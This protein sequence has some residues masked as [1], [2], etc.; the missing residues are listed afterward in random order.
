M[1]DVACATEYCDP[2][3]SR[4]LPLYL[5]AWRGGHAEAG[6][7]AKRL[8]AELG[9]HMALGEIATTDGDW[10]AAGLAFF[11]AGFP[12]LAVEPLKKFVEM[13]PAGASPVTENVRVEGVTA[14][15]TIARGARFDADREI[16][17]SLTRARSATGASAAAAYL[18]A[19]RV[20]RAAHLE[21]RLATILPAA[22]RA[23]PD[24]DTIAA[25]VAAR[26]FETGKTDELLA[27][28]TARLERSRTRAEHAERARAAGVELIARNLQPG[29][30]LRLLRMSL[31]HAYTELLPGITSHVAVWELLWTHAQVQNAATELMPLIV[32][33]LAAPL[34]A[35]DALYLA[36]LALEIT[37]RH[38][39]DAVAARPYAAMVI[40]FVPDHSLAV[41]FAMEAAPDMVAQPMLEEEPPAEPA[42]TAARC[43]GTQ[44]KP[45]ERF[46]LNEGQV[47][48]S[49]GAPSMTAQAH[50]I[51]SRIA[52][53]TSPASAPAPRPSPPPIEPAKAEV[54]THAHVAVA[55]HA[56][57]AVARHAQVAVTTHGPSKPPVATSSLAPNRPPVSSK[58]PPIA[59][60]PPTEGRPI[61]GRPPVA[62]KPNGPPAAA[63][64]A[65]P[66]FAARALRKVGPI[67]VV[68]ELPT[69]GF[70]STLLRDLSTS[71]AFILTKRQLDVGMVVSLEMQIPMPG[72]ATASSHRIS[73]RIVR[74]AEIGCG[75]AFID[76]TPE[77]VAAIRAF[78]A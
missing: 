6:V 72:K 68:V 60:K 69:G 3:R 61:K 32:Q 50:R 42:P 4:G 63:L 33:A 43:S 40:D 78:I 52:L 48:R 21:D 11:D 16:T 55:T 46:S 28:Y 45:T 73:A 67:D 62:G 15:F 2:D 44:V 9:A 22:V 66:P 26:L 27:H 35:D 5:D 29:L 13:R 57:V 17:D 20:A 74:S 1:F 18:Y 24:D 19:V 65:V 34:T 23:C 70:F 7:R 51:S 58:P 53:L 10:L 38:G 54:A 8:A 25:L 59:G 49:I 47:K 76:A 30:G 41:E 75:V 39:S 64:V 37:W 71:G 77:V 56:Q 31:E 14:L 36:R 12:E